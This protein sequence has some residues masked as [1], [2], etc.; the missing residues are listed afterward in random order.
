MSGDKYRMNF[1]TF[2]SLNE[3]VDIK[4]MLHGEFPAAASAKILNKALLALKTITLKLDM[5]EENASYTSFEKLLTFRV[6]SDSTVKF[7]ELYGLLNSADK[8]KI[9][10]LI[11]KELDRL[12]PEFDKLTSHVD[13]TV[14]HHK[15]E[16]DL[17][18]K[19]LIKETGIEL[20]LLKHIDTKL[21]IRSNVYLSNLLAMDLSLFNTSV[22]SKQEKDVFDDNAEMKTKVRIT[23]RGPEDFDHYLYHLKGKDKLQGL[24]FLKPVFQSLEKAFVNEAKRIDWAEQFEVR[25]SSTVSD[26]IKVHKVSFAFVRFLNS[27]TMER[28]SKLNSYEETKKINAIRDRKEKERYLNK[29]SALVKQCLDGLL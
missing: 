11:E 29:H 4:S 2:L 1:K 17:R 12:N 24:A 22:T 10:P 16:F 14:Y 8:L 7:L 18:L 13:W 20:P 15:L 23:L 9:K 26:L 21:D 25:M 5:Y 6:H 3:A 19:R 27:K 28:Y